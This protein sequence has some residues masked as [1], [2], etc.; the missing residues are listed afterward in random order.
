ML[1]WLASY[2]RS[3]NTLVRIVLNAA[4]GL[5][6]HALGTGDSRVFGSR[7][8]VLRL[9]G[10]RSDG[11]QDQDLIA[12]AR[13]SRELYIVKTHEPPVTDD[14]AIYVVRDGRSAIVSYS[15]YYAEVEGIP[16]SMP[17]VIDGK[18]YAGGWSDHFRAWSPLSRPRTLFVRYEDV[19]AQPSSLIAALA[20]FCQRAPVSNSPPSFPELHAAFPEFFRCGGDA[21][22]IQE[23]AP[24]I[25][26][27]RDRHGWLMQQ[28]G[29]W[30][31]DLRGLPYGL[32]R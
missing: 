20:E 5:R 32:D 7:P 15:H 8:G 17:D 6:T 28:L 24:F 16:I 23:I 30:A 18:V 27:F 12:E 21:A 13:A 22:N 29:Y 11:L 31:A 14:P 3:G 26:R 19:V 1:I 25:L 10:H 9:V 4:F 2:P